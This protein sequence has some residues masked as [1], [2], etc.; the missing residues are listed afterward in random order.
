MGHQAND[1]DTAL[2][3][4]AIGVDRHR[5]VP[6]SVWQTAFSAFALT[7]ILTFRLRAGD[8]LTLLRLGARLNLFNTV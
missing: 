6:L 5:P 3:A 4:G 7:A 1:V 2:L 8:I